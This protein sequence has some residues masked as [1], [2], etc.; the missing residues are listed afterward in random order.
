MRTHRAPGDKRARLAGLMHLTHHK[1]QCT[2]SI[3]ES[4]ALHCAS[5]KSGRIFGNVVT[6]TVPECLFYIILRGI[7]GLRATSA[8]LMAAAPRWRSEAV[9]RWH[10]DTRQYALVPPVRK[11]RVSGINLFGG[12]YVNG[13]AL[14]YEATDDEHRCACGC[15][16]AICKVP[17]LTSVLHARGD[18]Y[19]TT[20]TAVGD[21]HAPGWMRYHIEQGDFVLGVRGRCEMW[22]TA[23]RIQTL[24]NS[25][26]CGALRCVVSSCV[27][28]CVCGHCVLKYVFVCCV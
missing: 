8:S 13:M 6:A 16:R 11:G 14:L 12:A 28:E 1:N 5:M 17:A 3:R 22:V 25:Y 9:G 27:C 18:V 24:R 15:I 4:A 10:R 21:H 23:L 20:E 2:T 19:R 26:L 7:R